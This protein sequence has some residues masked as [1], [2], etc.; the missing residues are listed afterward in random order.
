MVAVRTGRDDDRVVVVAQV[1]DRHVAAHLDVAEQA[2]V[3]AL[4][5]LVQGDDD[6]LNARVVGRHTVAPK[7]VG[8]GKP[9]EKVDIHLEPRLRQDVRRV[10]ASGTGADDG[11][12]ERCQASS[13]SS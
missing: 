6:L 9:L 4:E 5:D 1:V 7:P 11:N 2:N 3:S 13:P 10:D 8:G 12:V